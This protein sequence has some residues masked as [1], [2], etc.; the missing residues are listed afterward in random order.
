ML[1]LPLL[2]SIASQKGRAAVDAECSLAC[3]KRQNFMSVSD[4]VSYE[5]CEAGSEEPETVIKAD[6][7]EWRENL[8]NLL[9]HRVSSYRFA[10]IECSSPIS[11]HFAQ[12][13][14]IVNTTATLNRIAA[15]ILTL[16]DYY[17]FLHRLC[18][19]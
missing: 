9:R 5:I 1:G 19:F 18:P 3:E 4:I 16:P 15:K 7:Y 13:K 11:F 14:S 10:L 8:S 17:C 2:A 6:E 12:K